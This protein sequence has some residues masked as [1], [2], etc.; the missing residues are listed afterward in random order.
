NALKL[1]L[2]LFVDAIVKGTTPIVSGKDGLKAL[3]VAEMIIAKIEESINNAK[4][5]PSWLND[6]E[7]KKLRNS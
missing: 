1:E 3:R 4:N 7:K 5:F 6:V 2:E